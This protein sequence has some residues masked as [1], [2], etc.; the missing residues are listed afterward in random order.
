M[1][2]HKNGGADALSQRGYA[3]GD[4]EED[5]TVDDYFDAKLY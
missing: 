4:A 5:D 1:P 2:G 3:E